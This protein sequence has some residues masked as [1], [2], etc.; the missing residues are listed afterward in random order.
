VK[1]KEFIKISDFDFLKKENTSESEIRSWNK[2]LPI[3]QKIFKDLGLNECE[4]ELEYKLP[5]SHDRVD[6][7][8]IGK[9]IIFLELKQWSEDRC[10]E[11]NKRFCI[12]D[13]KEFLHPCIQIEGYKRAFEL[14]CEDFNIETAVFLHNMNKGF[15][16][17]RTNIF[18]A[19]SIDGF[20]EF[21]IDNLLPVNYDNIIKFKNCDPKPTPKL[22]ENLD[23]LEEMIQLS[24][25][26]REVIYKILE[27]NKN[28]VLVE[29]APGSGK[30]LIA[31]MLHSFYLKKQILSLYFTKTATPRKVYSSMLQK[32]PA[33]LGLVYMDEQFV[34]GNIE[35]VKVIIID[36]AQRLQQKHID[37]LKRLNKK[38]IFFYDT[39]QKVQVSDIGDVSRYF[40]ENEYERHVL[41]EQY[42]CDVSQ[43]YLEF[44][45]CILYNREGYKKFDYDFKIC[46]NFDEFLKI[47]NDLNARI[48]SG[49]CYEWKSKNDENRFDIEIEGFKL[50][51][52]DFKNS[53]I[54]IIDDSQKNFVG[55]IHSIQGMEEDYIG[56]IV[57]EDLDIENNRL[58]ERPE[59]NQEFKKSFEEGLIKNIYRVL[60]TRARKGTFVYFTNK[61]LK[62]YFKERLNDCV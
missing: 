27:S 19:R 53:S 60:L 8:L 7:V 44:I 33:E 48:V 29:G 16:Y 30:S 57:C 55:C 46:E 39:Q 9:N 23:K 13:N 47:K 34:P 56:V 42:R 51:W 3:L 49:Y 50:K 31:L 1:V 15:N 61:K 25:E 59:K 18:Y 37:Y 24:I 6:V 36:E 21:L 10:V 12:V 41:K 58:I 40:S 54:W 28:I 22:I 32:K 11:K 17:C 5:Y 4:V 52:N 38:L 43:E 35:K 45:D 14:Y 20:R 2:S 62:E 26:Q